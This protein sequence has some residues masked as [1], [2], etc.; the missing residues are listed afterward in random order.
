MKEK[1]SILIADDN[2]EFAKTLTGYLENQEDM[3]VVGVAKD[4]NEAY[5]MIINRNPDIALLDVIMPNLDGL[6]VLEKL[7]DAKLEKG[8]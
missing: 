5:D 2:G 6:G 7:K 1:I 4:G 8:A 3:E